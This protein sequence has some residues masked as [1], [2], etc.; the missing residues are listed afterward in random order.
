LLGRA[1]GR[2][3]V[4]RQ[5]GCLEKRATKKKVRCHRCGGFGHFAKTCK[6]EMVG[7]DGETATNNKRLEFSSNYILLYAFHFELLFDCNMK[8]AG[9]E[10]KMMLIMMLDHPRG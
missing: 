8:T 10:Q 6:L 7:E 9:R 4:L 5:S 3:K 2:P 1:P